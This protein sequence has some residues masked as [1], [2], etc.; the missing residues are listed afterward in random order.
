M[1]TERRWI[2]IQHVPY[3]GPGLIA[4]EAFR[5]GIILRT[6]HPYRGESL[7]SVRELHGLIVMGGPMGVADTST[8]PYLPGEIELLATAVASDIPVLGV[9][10]GAQLLATALGARVYRGEQPE[11]GSGA[12]FLTA[13]GRADPVLGAAA[14]AFGSAPSDAATTT[15]HLSSTRTTADPEIPVIH[16]HHDTFDLPS[17]ATLLARSALYPHQAFRLG[18]LAYGLQFHI[19]VDRALINA[20]RP[21]LPDGVMLEERSCAAVERTGRAAITAFFDLSSSA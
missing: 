18:E 12:V 14:L 10:L 9:C 15:G 8:H 2:A 16:W 17:D 21:H 20:W 1:I 7:P 4:A 13:A 6:C 11:I 3:E 5:R 19:E